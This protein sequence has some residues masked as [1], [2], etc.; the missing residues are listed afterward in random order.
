MNSYNLKPSYRNATERQVNAQ[1]LITKAKGDFQDIQRKE[2][3]KAK[4]E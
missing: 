1:S 3:G 4:E 2:Q